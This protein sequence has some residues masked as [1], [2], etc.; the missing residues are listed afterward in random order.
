MHLKI[1]R[2]GMG[3]TEATVVLL[4]AASGA[5]ASPAVQ[6]GSGTLNLS[7]PSALLSLRVAG[8][9]TL[10]TESGSLSF[11]GAILGAG[12][13]T[14]MAVDHAAVGE[15]F[16]ARWSAPATVDGRSG[17]LTLHF[18]GKDNGAFSGSFTA[19]GSD[20]LDGLH[21]HGQ[22]SGSDA[23]GQGSYTLKYVG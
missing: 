10:V 16:T 15:T 18:V 1:L 9:N 6:L 4:T 2:C 8:T 5:F 7:P 12:S 20:G 22:F 3:L 19:D 21:G 13:I 23:T 11:V 17:T 14:V